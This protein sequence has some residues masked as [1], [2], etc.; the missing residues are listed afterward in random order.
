[1]AGH[2]KW[3]QI[4]RSKAKVASA[5][6]RSYP[7]GSNVRVVGTHMVVG[8][9]DQG[10]FYAQF[11]IG[12]RKAGERIR[13]D[14]GKRCARAHNAASPTAAIRSALRKFVQDFGKRDAMAESFNSR[15][16]SRRR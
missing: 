7:R 16:N 5:W 3:A 8:R 6:S 14:N 10:S 15:R 12:K 4:K 9:N 1:M 2:S 11:C 13:A